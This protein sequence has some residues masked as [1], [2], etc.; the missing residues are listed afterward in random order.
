MATDEPKVTAE[1]LAELREWAEQ[2]IAFGRHASDTGNQ[3]PHEAL[4]LLDA[5]TAQAA[6]LERLRVERSQSALIEGLPLPPAIAVELKGLRA[7]HTT[8]LEVASS[9]NWNIDTDK[10]MSDALDAYAAALAA[11]DRSQG[12]AKP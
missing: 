2:S 11:L 1:Q 9:T 3:A 5:Y 10:A 8:M 12:S 6:E 7:F 4:A